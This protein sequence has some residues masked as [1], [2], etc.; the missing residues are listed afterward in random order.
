MRRFTGGTLGHAPIR[1]ILKRVY[2]THKTLP[3]TNFIY[4]SNQVYLSYIEKNDEPCT[5]GTHTQIYDNFLY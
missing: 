3:Q 5:V 4:N 2:R 1:L